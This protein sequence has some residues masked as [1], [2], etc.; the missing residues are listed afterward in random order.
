MA[1][2]SSLRSSSSSRASGRTW[3][4]GRWPGVARLVSATTASSSRAAASA[5]G[6]GTTAG[7]AGA[8]GGVVDRLGQR[9]VLLVAGGDFAGN[10][11]ELV[12]YAELVAAADPAAAERAREQAGAARARLN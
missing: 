1:W 9:G 5:G 6:G 2:V 11:R 4:S 10:A 8:A 12:G 7:P 3:C